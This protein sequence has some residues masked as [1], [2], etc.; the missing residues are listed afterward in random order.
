MLRREFC[1]GAV[2]AG[3]M[4]AP[5]WS[6]PSQDGMRVNGTRLNTHLRALSQFGRTPEGG[7]SRVAYS[8][9]DLAGREYVI[10]LMRM[11]QL[12][13]TVDAAG[14]I[15]GRRAGSISSLPPLMMGSHIDSVPEGGNYDGQVGSSTFWSPRRRPWTR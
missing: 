8:E 14:N 11:A 13:T 6:F 2:A 10:G 12:E 4:L 7:I 3:A 9:A 1:Q 5:A 15:V